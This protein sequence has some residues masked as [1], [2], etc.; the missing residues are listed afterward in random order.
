MNIVKVDRSSEKY[1]NHNG[2]ISLSYDEIVRISNAL[3]FK[4]KEDEYYS[5][6]Y[7]DWRNFADVV[8]YG[9]ITSIEGD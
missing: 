9:K 1:S 2:T 6:L 7:K 3:Y 4:W 8:C 5:Q